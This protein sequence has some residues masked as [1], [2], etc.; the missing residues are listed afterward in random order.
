MVHSHV[1]IHLKT[2]RRIH[3]DLRNRCGKLKKFQ[4]GKRT[5]SPYKC[6]WIS[7]MYKQTIIYETS[8]SLLFFV[9]CASF[10]I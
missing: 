4:A 2:L 1:F 3:P 6:G 9:F 7:A 10:A 5:E 8:K